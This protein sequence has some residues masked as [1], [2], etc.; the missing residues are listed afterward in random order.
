ML[1]GFEWLEFLNCNKLPARQHLCLS[2][3]SPKPLFSVPSASSVW[4]TS[5]PPSAPFASWCYCFI[6]LGLLLFVIFGFYFKNLFCCEQSAPGQEHCIHFNENSLSFL[7]PLE[8]LS[9]SQDQPQN[10]PPNHPPPTPPPPLK[11]KTLV[12][13]SC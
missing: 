13:C 8:V 3:L 5:L 10:Q 9:L 4:F 1:C 6:K 7:S 2:P 12:H 11:G